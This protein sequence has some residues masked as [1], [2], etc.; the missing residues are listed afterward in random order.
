MYGKIKH[1]LP[2]PSKPSNLL[3]SL[4]NTSTTP[5]SSNITEKKNSKT[6]EWNVSLMRKRRY[7]HLHTHTHTRAHTHTHTH[8][9]VTYIDTITLNTAVTSL[10]NEAP[11]YPWKQK[12]VSS[13]A[14]FSHKG[15]VLY[16][17]DKQNMPSSNKMVIL[18]MLYFVGHCCNKS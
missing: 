10:R 4:F 1:Q 7:I 18:W 14:L 8:T 16:K 5:N 12:A 13:P 3:S 9:M 15:K 6:T 11:S 2:I 17:A